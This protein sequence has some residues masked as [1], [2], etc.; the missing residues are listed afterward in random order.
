MDNI[1]NVVLQMLDGNTIVGSDNNPS[2]SGKYLCT[3]V[4]MWQGE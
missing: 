1:W 3:C 4:T 2:E